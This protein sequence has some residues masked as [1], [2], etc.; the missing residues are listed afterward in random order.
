MPKTKLPLEPGAVLDVVKELRAE[1]QRDAPL[2][3]SGAP[4]LASTLRREL[5]RGGVASA[6]REQG[7]LEDAAALVHVVAGPV[8]EEDERALKQ[9]ARK[10]I[11][12]VVV[13]SGRPTDPVVHIPYVLDVNVVRVAPGGGFPVPRIAERLAHALGD[14]GTALAARLPILRRPVCE[15][16]IRRYS[17]RNA[18]VGAAIFLPGADLPV[19]TLNQI[20]LVLR[21]ADAYGFEIDRERLP[22][23][24]G[25]IG[26]GLGFRALARRSIG[27]VPFVGWAIKGA[28]AYAGTRALGEAAMRYFERRAP[29]TRIAGARTLFPR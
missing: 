20:R 11:P 12:I 2:V 9:A 29:V 27:F 3:V 1:A 10:R 17:R 28:V 15:E 23:V 8:D 4:E 19:L 5:V 22:E 25:V 26:S 21:I 13:T 6:V 14:A 16:L 7:P 24:L 18:F